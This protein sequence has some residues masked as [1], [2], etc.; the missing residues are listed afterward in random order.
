M[1]RTDL[2]IIEVDHEARVE[3]RCSA[4]LGLW[5]DKRVDASWEALREALVA[6]ELDYLAS[7]VSK[8]LSPTQESFSS[9]VDASIGTVNFDLACYRIALNYGPGIYFFPATFHPG[10]LM[11][12]A[13]IRDWRL[14]IEVLNQSFQA[15][16]SNGN[17]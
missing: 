10:H 1:S 11:R 12:P 4:M 6:V 3:R 5:L 7:K 2:D 8:W 13:T 14:L 9:T 17:W 16:N 15:M